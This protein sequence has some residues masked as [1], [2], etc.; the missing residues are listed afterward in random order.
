MSGASRV[1]RQSEY[2]H[3]SSESPCM[4]FHTDPEHPDQ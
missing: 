2:F 1:D 3:L 4:N